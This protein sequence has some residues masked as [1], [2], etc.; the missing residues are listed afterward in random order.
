METEQPSLKTEGQIFRIDTTRADEI[1]EIAKT[2][3]TMFTSWDDFVK[4]CLHVYIKSW[5]DP[6]KALQISQQV[7]LPH[8]KPEQLEFMKEIMPP[9]EYQKFT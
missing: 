8:F 5:T 1:E 7:W 6:A 4:E 2:V 3:T 9:E